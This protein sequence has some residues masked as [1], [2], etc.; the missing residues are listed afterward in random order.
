MKRHTILISAYTC[1]PYGV[2]ES[3]A[4]FNF[5][6]ILLKKY[7]I[8]LL[9]TNDNKKNISN[10]K[11]WQ[12]LISYVPQDIYLKNGSFV[13]NIAFG[14]NIDEVDFKKISNVA[15]KACIKEFIENTKNGA[16]L[17]T[18]LPKQ[19]IVKY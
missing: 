15:K 18:L 16:V 8:I 10:L 11:K 12:K 5:I 17:R 9:T 2:S 13:D 7:S 14:L 1:D 4:A 19:N 3:L 6:K